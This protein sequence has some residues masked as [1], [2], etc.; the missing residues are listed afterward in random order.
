MIISDDAKLSRQMRGSRA[1]SG[2]GG[3]ADSRRSPSRSHS[4]AVSDAASIAPPSA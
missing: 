1:A 2:A 3:A 4:P